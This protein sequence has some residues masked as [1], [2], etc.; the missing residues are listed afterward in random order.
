MYSTRQLSKQS[1][2][3]HNLALNYPLFR[4]LHSCSLGV[5]LGPPTRWE[6]L[7]S[8]SQPTVDPSGGPSGAILGMPHKYF[9]LSP[10]HSLDLDQPSLSLSPSLLGCDHP[11]LIPSLLSLA[12]Y[13]DFPEC[14][15]QVPSMSTFKILPAQGTLFSFFAIPSPKPCPETLSTLP[16]QQLSPKQGQ[17]RKPAHLTQMLLQPSLLGT[18]LPA[19]EPP[20]L[21]L[22]ILPYP[23]VGISPTS[24]KPKGNVLGKPTTEISHVCPMGTHCL[25]GHGD[26]RVNHKTVGGIAGSGPSCPAL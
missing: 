11:H 14:E 20:P 4:L 2:K 19:S 15:I 18:P 8:A 17:S 13:S 12:T 5:W 1:I 24:A 6:D 23:H 25:W 22:H 26:V 21:H 16:G 7:L 3:L 10:S 9:P